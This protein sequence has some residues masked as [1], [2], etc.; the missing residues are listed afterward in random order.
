[1]KRHQP[2]PLGFTLIELLVTISI[3]TVLLGF[4]MP[5]L[6]RA[7]EQ[8]KQVVCRN[9]LRNIWTGVLQY[10]FN[11]RDRVPF[12]EDINLDDPN[13]DPFD[14]RYKTTVG[15]VLKPYVHEGSWK[16]PSA[17]AGFPKAAGP[18]GWTMTYW[19]R[20]AGKMGEG[21]P[22]DK[23]NWGNGGPLDPIVS[24][25]VNFDGRPLRLLSGR[26][27]TPSNPLAPNKD[28]VGPWTFSFPIIADLMEGN[29]TQGRPKYP[30]YGVVD[31]RLDLQKAREMFERN[32]GVGRL[33]ARMELHAE[34][35]KEMNMYLTRSPF[36]HRPGY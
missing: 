7:R 28:A 2:P 13:A 24:N 6:N 26:R 29:E 17:I 25:Y 34:G 20:T 31:K 12:M 27:H 18:E 35:E 33:P 11:S 10:M 19:F 1:M 23:T 36:A 5:S 22:F 16:C 15:V 30:H 8:A 3:I 9:N 21:V 14:P 32:S 4:L